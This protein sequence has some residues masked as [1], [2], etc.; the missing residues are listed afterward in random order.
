[1]LACAGL[2][3]SCLL[4]A[5]R[6]AP[7][8]RAPGQAL[9]HD[10]FR[11][12]NKNDDG[13]LSFGEFKNY[14]ADGILSAEELWELF[15][16]VD[17]RHSDNVETEK[18]C[19]YFS[20]HLGEYSHV[21]SALE[22]LN[23]AVLA[24]MDRAKLAYESSSEVEQFVTRFL[25]RETR[26]QLQGLQAS[27][28]CAADTLDQQAGR[29]RKGLKTPAACPGPR[30]ARRRGRRAR[31]PV[32]LAPTDPSSGML[33]TG[34][35]VAAGS[36]WAAPINRLQQLLDTLERQSPR[37]EPLRD[38]AVCKGRTAHILVAQRQLCVAESGLEGFQ[39]ALQ[40]YAELTASR[41]RCLHHLQSGTSK[42]FQGALANL[43]ESPELVTTMILPAS[44]WIMNN[45]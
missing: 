4:P 17:G 41:S 30:S 33:T 39:Q 34:V 37:L 9:L 44:W 7:P 26:S 27:L 22:A 18:L 2:L 14:F 19:D 13:R 5:P 38:D 28:E 15:S 42:T 3:A 29:E 12:A 40:A 16:G 6:P 25:L 8:P 21:L 35:C 20:A 32:C 43:L 24:A 23:T 36:Q 45:N 11:R 1:M 31:R 10:V